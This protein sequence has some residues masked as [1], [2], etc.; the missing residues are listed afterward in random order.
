[1]NKDYT[2]EEAVSH[3]M[4]GSLGIEIISEEEGLVK[5]KMP[6]NDSTSQ[7]FGVLCGAL[8]LRLRKFWPDTVLS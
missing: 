6:V 7:P 2:R 8:R 4:I 1:M 3:S 5:A